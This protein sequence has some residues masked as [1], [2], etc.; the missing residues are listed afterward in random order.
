MFQIVYFWT[1]KFLWSVLFPY[2]TFTFLGASNKLV[3]RQLAKNSLALLLNKAF[4]RRTKI[5][6][7]HAS[8]NRIFRA[9]IDGSEDAEMERKQKQHYPRMRRCSVPTAIKKAE[10]SCPAS[11]RDDSSVQETG[12]SS[13]N[14]NARTPPHLI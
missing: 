14:R 3:G 1:L 12:I 6:F 11:P 13:R 2:K 5:P 8:R 9:N 7:T 4:C 10:F